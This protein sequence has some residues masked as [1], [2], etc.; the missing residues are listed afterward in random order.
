MLSILV[1]IRLTLPFFFVAQKTL[2]G[3][4]VVPRP[5]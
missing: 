1:I 5:I 4:S 2:N 3:P